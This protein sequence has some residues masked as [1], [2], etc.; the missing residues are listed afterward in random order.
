MQA[1]I[2]ERLRALPGVADASAAQVLP[3]AGGLW[4]RDV[5]VE[6]YTFRSDE[7]ESVG[8]NVIAPAY[9]ATIGTPVVAGREFD[10]RDGGHAP[11]AIVNEAFA[12]YFFGDAS[13]LGRRVTSLDLTYTIVG[14]VRDAKYQSLRHGIIKTMYIPWTLRSEDQPLRYSYLV[15]LESTDRASVAASLDRA[16]RDADPALRLRNVIS[17]AT[18]VDRS[19]VAERLMAALAGIFGV[20]ALLI[21]AL[22]V[23]G[24]LAFQVAR[25]TSEFGLRTA[26]GANRRTL[27]RLVL[28]DVAVMVAAGVTIGGAVSLT[29]T[30]LARRILFDVA[31]HDPLVF[32]TAA[33]VL[34]GAALLAAWLPARRAARVD[35]LIA[36]RHE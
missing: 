33:S 20:L 15:R 19:L 1:A 30:G 17:Y 16:V 29:V 26:L 34:V 12:R 8:F 25:R 2:I 24:V 35:P 13:P 36:L 9:F 14:V 32:A 22:G 10:P 18:L 3:L 21:A 4:N 28:R 6:G 27:M 7:S 11:V 5:A 31:P 23:F